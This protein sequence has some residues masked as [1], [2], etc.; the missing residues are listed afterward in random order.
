MLIHLEMIRSSNKSFWGV[1]Q[2]RILIHLHFHL[3]TQIRCPDVAATL[4]GRFGVA[5]AQHGGGET[6]SASEKEASK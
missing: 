4:A 5:F 6:T 1:T 2:I 3:G